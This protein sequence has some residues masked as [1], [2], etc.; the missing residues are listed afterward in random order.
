MMMMMMLFLLL[1]LLLYRPPD[2]STLIFI[3]IKI[4]VTTEMENP[5]TLYKYI[6]ISFLTPLFI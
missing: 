1:L 2:I 3:S 6:N 5:T 4:I